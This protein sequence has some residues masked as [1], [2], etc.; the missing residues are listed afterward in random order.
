MDK[1]N[2]DRTNNKE[3]EQEEKIEA[4]EIYYEYDFEDMGYYDEMK[5]WG[6]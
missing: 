1:K 2:V 5:L 6:E 3:K 4:E